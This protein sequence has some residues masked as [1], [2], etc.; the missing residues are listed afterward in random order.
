[1]F[2]EKN[3]KQI[4][5][6]GLSEASVKDQI[7]IF[8]DG[9]P[10]SNVVEAASAGNG[11]EVLSSEQ[12]LDFVSLFDTKKR[13]LELLKFVP[14]SG[15][16]TRMFKFLHQFLD[17]Y[18]E[19]EEID[20][21]L[22]KKEHLSLKTFF[23]SVEKFP[24]LDLVKKNLDEKYPEYQTLEKAKKHFLLVKEMLEDSGLNFSNTPKGLIPFHKYDDDS[25]T[26]FGEQLYEAA[27][28]ATSN[29]T[30]NLHFTISKEHEEKFKESFEQTKSS[31]ENKTGINNLFYLLLHY[32][33]E[34]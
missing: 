13:G 33:D 25:V 22:Q 8:K 10:F 29:G 19:S 31:I 4:E 18:N 30:A 20:T 26:A 21:F 1:M 2:T 9:I 28:Y 32:N 23:N 17:N 7:Q 11:I 15:A 12:Q 34:I 16:V 6:H 27:F 14:A 5:A 3:I 24:F